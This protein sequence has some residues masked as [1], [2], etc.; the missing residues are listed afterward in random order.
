[1]IKII[2]ENDNREESVAVGTKLEELAQSGNYIA[3]YVDGVSEWLGY[4][5]NSRVAVRFISTSEREGH[6][7]Y[8]RGATFLLQWA[9]RKVYGDGQH[10]SVMHSAGSG[11]YIE[12]AGG[13]VPTKEE[14]REVE[15]KMKEAVEANKTISKHRKSF[16]EAVAIYEQQGD[17]DKVELH[18]YQRN[19]WVDMYEL[20]GLW[21]EFFGALPMSTGVIRRFALEGLGSGFVLRLPSRDDMSVVQPAVLSEKLY[22]V[23]MANEMWLDILGVGNVGALNSRI[24]RGDGP[25]IIRIGEALQEKNFS[26]VADSVLRAH[27]SRGVKV[28]FV[29]GPS[30]SG[31][32]TFTRRLGIQ[33]S[34]VGLEPRII[35]LDDYFVDR[36]MTPRDENGELDLEAFE[37]IDY[38]RFN[39]D[40]QRLLQGE[41]VTLPR[42]DFLE[43]RSLPSN[44]SI[45]LDTKSILLVEGIHALNPRLS[46]SFHELEDRSFR[47]YVSALTAL[48][49][50]STSIIHTSDNR[51]LR[52]MVRDSKF[53]GRSA[54]VT[55]NGWQSVRRGEQKHIFPYQEEADIMFN[56]ALP[57]EFSILRRYAEPL[58]RAIPPG[59]EA[60]YESRRLLRFL[61]YFAELD[62]KNIP[63]TSLIREFL[64]GSAF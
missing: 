51:L 15:T 49:M 60:Y 31:K 45:S 17:Q 18:S 54:E 7:V 6:R 12:L 55:I 27:Q 43:G 42:F 50:D 39:G 13:R 16:E 32:T 23:F 48:S 35:S 8:T 33:L 9:V 22:G 61:E 36:E 59:S 63:A 57:F 53:R 21:G 56:T 38:K 2:I 28:V 29:S 4:E 58:L 25:D 44:V 19:Y 34:V 62:D 24:A 37:A 14:L 11:L 3:A 20:D 47:I 5:V 40:L 52:R 10:I 64:G 1:M 26:M 46:G 30:S 41:M